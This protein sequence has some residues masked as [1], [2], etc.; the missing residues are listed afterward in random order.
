MHR[1]IKAT[2]PLPS[3]DNSKICLGWLAVARGGGLDSWLLARL[4]HWMEEVLK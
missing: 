1:N 2:L 4:C 3:N